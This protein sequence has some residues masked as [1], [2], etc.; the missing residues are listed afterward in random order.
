MEGLL[1]TGPTPSSLPF[2]HFFVCFYKI[3]K[4]KVLPAQE[5]LFLEGLVKTVNQEY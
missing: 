5:N 3:V 4:G 2:L 1:S